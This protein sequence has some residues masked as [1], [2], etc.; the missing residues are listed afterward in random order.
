MCQHL[1]A[2]KPDDG[3]AMG[4]LVHTLG[5]ACRPDDA[6]AQ[7]RAF[8]RDNPR[9]EV[10]C[11]TVRLA[12]AKVLRD[13]RKCQEA[14]QEYE[15]LLSR[16]IGRI[17][18][19]YYGLS[20]S[21][22][23]LGD[24]KKAHQILADLVSLTGPDARTRLLLADLFSEDFDDGPAVELT[25]C[26]LKFEP[27][28]L[29]ALIRLADAEGRLDRQTGKVADAVETAKAIL[30]L[31]PTNV[32][33]RLALARALAT[34]QD[35][36]GSASAYEP[37]IAADP[38]FLVPRREQARALYSAN[39]YDAGA[40]AYAAMLIPSA[41]ERLH[42][43]LT[44]LAQRDA[45]AGLAL[46]PCLA[47]GLGGDTLTAEA[48]KAVA[49]LGDAASQA[50][51][52]RL[53]LDYQARR[54]EQEGSHL[55]GEVKDD[56]W[57][58][59]EATPIAKSL[60]AL[61]PSNTSALFDL[62][63][64]FSC[65]RLTHAAI[66]QYAQDVTI[67]PNEYEA[68]TAL[69][70]AGLELRPR[71]IAGVDFFGEKGFD[72]LAHIQRTYYRSQVQLP[73]G[74]EDEFFSFGF[75]RGNL[76]PADDRP[77]EANILSAGWQEKFCCDG[78]LLLYGQ[79][80]L[81]LYPNR[82]HD[83]VTF[84]A[85]GRYDF[86]DLV[87]GRAGLF[88]ENVA[89]NGESMRQDIYR[90]GAR[91]GTDVQPARIWSLAGTGTIYHYSDDNDALELFLK[92]DVILLPPPCQL[93]FVLTTDM[94]HYRDQSV[95]PEPSHE[96]LF[97]MLHPYFAPNFYA[98]YEAR[99]EW[100]HWISRDY[101]AHSNQCWYSV[102]YGVGWDNSFNMYNTAR[103]TGNFDVRPWL[104]LSAEAQV[105]GSPV[106]REAQAMGYVTIR[107]P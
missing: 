20:R 54:T 65:L 97:G 51:L 96:I 72:G 53:F 30:V 9:N 94:L 7:A 28:N 70:R 5:K 21:L 66:E 63:Q 10:A 6:E 40:A 35:Y 57:R 99:L 46:G 12:L 48:T 47:A 76:V 105:I 45:R 71:A 22:E 92:S 59:Y 81:E 4:Q 36:V 62:G 75:T 52:Q 102:Q 77:L 3:A 79:G 103:L 68:M 42:A 24:G 91:L 67:D 11:L 16:P 83:R 15:I 49:G 64:E 61:E 31:S 82:F 80:N 106:Y 39:K 19:S 86:C 23:C 90:Y 98:Y 17:P 14:A 84:D 50:A 44:A 93:K 32:R 2:E 1:L 87:T 95:F 73:F 55:E 41:D 60:V 29:A 27:D 18:E 88:L 69:G 8:L 78:R 74:D 58:H 85:G 33:G 34:A 38:D 100:K 13:A 89:E 101:F 107:L 104:T 37:L 56:F 26:V 25:Q 43:D